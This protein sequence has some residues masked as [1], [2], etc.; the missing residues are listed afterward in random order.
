VVAMMT[1][2]EIA[3]RTVRP[4]RA[5]EANRT[6]DGRLPLPPSAGVNSVKSDVMGSLSIC[7]DIL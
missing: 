5:C 1:R 7:S 4:S 6:L 3:P 2:P